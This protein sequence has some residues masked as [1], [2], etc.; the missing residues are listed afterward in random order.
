VVAILGHTDA[1]TQRGEGARG[2]ERAREH[3]VRRGVAR[4]A[5]GA[6]GLEVEQ[7]DLA[8]L[9]VVLIERERDL[10][11]VGRDEADVVHVEPEI[12]CRDR[13]VRGADAGVAPTTLER[14]AVHARSE[15]ELDGRPRRG[16]RTAARE[17]DEDGTAEQEAETV[18]AQSHVHLERV[19]RA[20]HEIADAAQRRTPPR[21]RWTR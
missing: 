3:R 11:A 14:L 7:G 1:Q 20:A 9:E 15:A 5:R 4:A 17:R 13:R 8:V 16:G 2:G 12:L 18:R 6:A 19:L 21:S 10:G